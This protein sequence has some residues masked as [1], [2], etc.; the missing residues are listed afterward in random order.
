MSC[1]TG[2][3]GYSR[4]VANEKAK[5]ASRRHEEALTAYRCPECGEWHFGH[6]TQRT[7]PMRLI[8]RFHE[9]RGAR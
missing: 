5:R 1:P 2:K 7:R 6:T 3:P 8:H 9:M 4:A